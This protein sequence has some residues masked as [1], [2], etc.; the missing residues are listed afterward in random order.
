MSS[1]A[2]AAENAKLLAR[3]AELEA[4]VE[5]SASA[6]AKLGTL[7][8]QVAERTA[9]I[10]HRNEQLWSEIQERIKT[11]SELE[12]ARDEAQAA[13]NAKSRFLANMSHE[14]RTP[15]NAIIGYAEML[16]EEAD[17]EGLDDFTTDLSKIQAAGRHLLG[18]IN[19]ILD[20]S[21][22]EAGR[23]DLYWEHAQLE[24]LLT[25]VISTIRPL[26][27]KNENALAVDLHGDLGT[28]RTDVTKLR[29]VLFNLLSNAAKF[30]E[31]GEISLRVARQSIAG[32]DWL[33]YEVTDSGVGMSEAQIEHLFQPFTQADA[34]TTRK[35]GGTGLGLAISRR[36]CEMMGGGISVRS[37]PSQ[38][39]TFEVRLPAVP[40][41]LEQ[42]DDELGSG[43]EIPTVLV[44]D[45]D[46]TARDLLRRFLEKEGYAVTLARDGREALSLVADRRPSVI[47]LDV[48]MPGMDGW[49]VLSHLKSDPDLATI[50]VVMV[51]IVQDF[52]MG[53]ALGA[54][55]FVR[56]PIEKQRLLGVLRKYT[57]PVERGHALVVEDD[58]ESRTVLRRMLER[59]GWS[60][61]EAR[62]GKDGLSALRD[63]IPSIVFL[64]LMMPEMDGF[65]FLEHVKREPLWS[66]LPI[67]VVTA[68]DLTN[69]DRDR[70]SGNVARVMQKGEYT[71][72]ALLDELRRLIGVHLER[73]ST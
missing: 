34:S 69:E 54:S 51:T 48:M 71:R 73:P 14:L 57:G 47:T 66:Q 56:K 16:Q 26:I 42:I 21:K 33:V 49:A 28:I 36:F 35:F 10:E 58:L 39:S 53:Y 29:Q 8:A 67:V 12:R 17:E 2:L 60:V 46:E 31:R 50:P 20:I 23:M 61:T 38:G 62:H 9:E 32:E 68:K 1:D 70:L 19:D 45:D 5:A 13:N 22:I 15:L 6:S 30:T 27:E 37:R 24:T 72:E 44:V 11:E 43:A 64:D 40:L 55:D 4:Q 52:N 3:V 59:E 25:E 18:L 41:E 65:E 7:E 63:R